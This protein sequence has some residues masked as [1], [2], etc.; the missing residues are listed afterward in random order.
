MILILWYISAII[1][2]VYAG[3]QQSAHIVSKVWCAAVCFLALAL[4][5]DEMLSTLSR[6]QEP[7][8][9]AV[10]SL[11]RVQESM[12]AH[13]VDTKSAELSRLQHIEKYH[14]WV[15]GV[16]GLSLLLVS[17]FSQRC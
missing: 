7:A 16:T 6:V 12:V 17:W 10:D 3:V 5:R 14:V 13:A 9:V 15:V 4:L 11:S 8:S 2:A 1:V